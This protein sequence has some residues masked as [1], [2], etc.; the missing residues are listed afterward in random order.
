MQP[1]IRTLPREIVLWW[2]DHFEDEW[3]DHP[4]RFDWQEP[5]CWACGVPGGSVGK[6]G[7]HRGHLVDAAFR[8]AD[9][10][11]NL[12]LLC[13]RCNLLMPAFN[14]RSRAIDWLRCSPSYEEMVMPRIRSTLLVAARERWDGTRLREA[15]LGSHGAAFLQLPETWFEDWNPSRW[16]EAARQLTNGE[17]P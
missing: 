6:P 5:V 16:L 9:V 4:Q 13:Y 2:R 15:L 12:V 10:P 3:A 8:G 14:N 1:K 7:L 17:A 11:E